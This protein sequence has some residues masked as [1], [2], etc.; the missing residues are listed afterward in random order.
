MTSLAG[1]LFLS[2]L[3]FLGAP[4]L[5]ARPVPMRA[6]VVPDART[7]FRPGKQCVASAAMTSRVTAARVM[8]Q[9][10]FGAQSILAAAAPGRFLSASRT[11]DA[12]AN[13]TLDVTLSEGFLITGTIT[14]TGP[15]QPTDITAT[16]ALGNPFSGTLDTLNTYRIPVPAGSYSLRVCFNVAVGFFGLPSVTYNDPTPVDATLG[17]ATRDITLPAVVAKV[18]GA[19][20][21][22]PHECPGHHW[23][24][25]RRRM[26][27]ESSTCCARYWSGSLR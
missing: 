16:D 23:E 22:Q 18:W 5:S 9:Q 4:S 12:S 3:G 11:V 10:A 20:S 25:P 15:E 17:D 21:V 2:F 7:V 26:C 14:P 1:A 27:V 6:G 8:Q 13:V 19:G 24:D